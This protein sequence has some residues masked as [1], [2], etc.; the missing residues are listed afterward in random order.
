[1]LPCNNIDFQETVKETMNCRRDMHDSGKRWSIIDIKEWI[2]IFKYRTLHGAEHIDQE[3]S[4]MKRW[5]RKRNGTYRWGGGSW[6]V[7]K[8]GGRG[9][10]MEILTRLSRITWL[11]LLYIFNHVLQLRRANTSVV[12][13]STPPSLLL[14][15]SIFSSFLLHSADWLKLER[16][17]HWLVRS[18]E[19]GFPHRNWS[20]VWGE[21]ERGHGGRV[22]ASRHRRW[23]S[24]HH[25]LYS[26]FLK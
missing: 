20:C 10:R 19:E 24:Q 3:T 22:A 1:M 7:E 18:E 8:G 4:K 13:D 2:Y 6:E 16:R 9:V 26:S 21:R 5:S 11:N 15:E 14:Q 25:M 23:C 17:F 12:V